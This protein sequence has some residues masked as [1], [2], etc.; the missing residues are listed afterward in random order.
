M[1]NYLSFF[2]VLCSLTGLPRRQR[3]NTTTRLRRMSPTLPPHLHRPPLPSTSRLVGLATSKQQEPTRNGSQATRL[4][5]K[6]SPHSLLPSRRILSLR[7]EW[8][9]DLKSPLLSPSKTWPRGLLLPPSMRETSPISVQS[10]RLPSR[11]VPR[12]QGGS[13]I[14]GGCSQR[15]LP[16]RE[17]REHR[18]LD[19]SSTRI[20]RETSSSLPGRP[21]QR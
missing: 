20:Q 18:S 6:L 10:R 3:L 21:S 13:R 4:L 8:A 7:V 2:I 1:T 17:E 11:W 15:C 19:Q 12:L 16:I 5:L 9:T 14:Q